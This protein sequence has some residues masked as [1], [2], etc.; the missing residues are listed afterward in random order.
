MKKLGLIFLGILI[1]ALSS[2]AR[3]Q[4]KI[5]ETSNGC[6][7]LA[8][9]TASLE[10]ERISVKDGFLFNK[11]TGVQL[12]DLKQKSLVIILSDMGANKN[13]VV[14]VSKEEGRALG[15]KGQYYYL[16]DTIRENKIIKSASVRKKEVLKAY[17]ERTKTLIAID[18]PQLVYKPNKFWG[19]VKLLQT[20]L[21]F[22][23]IDP[24]TD[25]EPTLSEV[26]V[27]HR[28][29]FLELIIS[30]LVIFWLA[31]F[32]TI[33][34]T[35]EIECWQLV[36]KEK[37]KRNFCLG[38]GL[39]LFSL[40]L[41]LFIWGGVNK[42]ETII[43]IIAL[44]VVIVIVSFIL[45]TI[46]SFFFGVKSEKYHVLSWAIFTA[47]LIAAFYFVFGLSW[48]IFIPI[49]GYFSWLWWQRKWLKFKV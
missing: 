47:L 48:Q 41:P 26:P 22:T 14:P 45:G 1:I 19:E 18:D 2:C 10:D 5:V 42:T 8:A 25:W 39:I 35:E 33:A 37:F 11:K 7:L 6:Y 49:L 20:Y 34:T 40:M 30:A 9:D 44:S 46:L 43:G 24:A 29:P 28:W 4:M 31:R 21:N 12:S 17:G 16:I 36:L 32:L 27:T 38:I 23:D 3:K 13:L 15:F